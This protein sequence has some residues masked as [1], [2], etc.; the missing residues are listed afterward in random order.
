MTHIFNLLCPHSPHVAPPQWEMVAVAFYVVIAASQEFQAR[1]SGLVLLTP[2]CLSSDLK[3]FKFI[4]PSQ[5]LLVPLDNSV[6]L[7]PEM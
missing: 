4:V 1:A 6:S 7:S 5:S 3:E 2:G